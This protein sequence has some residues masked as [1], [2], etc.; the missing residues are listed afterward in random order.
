MPMS[1]N[2]LQNFVTSNSMRVGKW[3]YRGH[4][5]YIWKLETSYSRFL[6]SVWGD[7]FA[8][9]LDPFR[10]MLARFLRRAAEYSGG[11]YSE[12]SVFQ[13]MALAQHH[14]IP[15]PM[16]D[17]SYS[18]YVAAYFALANPSLVVPRGVTVAIHALDVT[19]VYGLEQYKSGEP[20]R[21]D[22]PAMDFRFVDTPLFSSRRITRQ[23]GCFTFQN[24]AT[25]VC[26]NGA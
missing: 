15:T 7:S 17:W 6:R 23:L 8:F 22:L 26:K 5:K 25:D 10:S 13:Q 2:E 14:G 4:T 12:Y 21:V 18:P 1:F 20:D 11:S 16:L 19:S 3:I 24:F 9:T